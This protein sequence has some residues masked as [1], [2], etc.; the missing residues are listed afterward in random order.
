MDRT[1]KLRPTIMKTNARFRGPTES[2]KYMNFIGEAI[3]DLI[4]LNKVMGTNNRKDGQE[5]LIENNFKT[6]VNGEGS[7]VYANIASATELHH[8]EASWFNE[9]ID[10]STTD[11]LAYGE[12][13]KNTSGEH[14]VLEVPGTMD[15]AG[16]KTITSVEE[17]DIIYIRMAVKLVSGEAP[18]FTIGSTD[19]N[20]DLGSFS[21]YSLP[22][23]G[24]IGYVDHMI[25]C[26]Y[27]ETI[28]L[29][30]D[31][32]R[33]AETLAAGSVEISDIEIVR[34]S[35]NDLKIAPINQNV[36]ARVNHLTSEITN[37]LKN[38]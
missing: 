25:E 27:R 11:W 20:R 32:I 30:I 17:G 9:P 31:V 26:L 38:L 14:I 28:D 12:L 1:R 29:N 21:Q 4:L 23:D 35:K 24:L 3:H 6:F 13:V 19:V 36:K 18:T 2:K 15:P 34:F 22:T 33:N 37:I 5:D 16:I 8:K 10:L 7:E